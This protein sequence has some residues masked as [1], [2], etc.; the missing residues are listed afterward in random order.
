MIRRTADCRVGGACMDDGADAAV[1]SS[2]RQMRLR[3]A[4]A[5]LAFCLLASGQTKPGVSGVERKSIQRKISGQH[6]AAIYRVA[7][8][9]DWMAITS[10]ATWVA[11]ANVNHV[12]QLDAATDRVAAIVTVSNPCSGLA[13]DFGS[14]W[15]PS[16]GA[17]ALFRVD[18]EAGKIIAKISV[19]PANSEGGITTGAGSVWV[20]TRGGLARI[21]AA[22]NKV[23]ALIRIPSGSYA[24]AFGDGAVWIT[25]TKHSRLTRVD[26]RTNRA[27]ATIVVG[28]RPRFLAVGGGSV[29]TLNQGDG[30]VSR[31]EMKTN[32]LVATIPVGT[33]GPGGEIVFGE[34]AVWTTFFGFP[35]TRIDPLLNRVTEQWTGAGGDSI[36]V[37]DGM[38]WLT[39]YKGGTVSR[40]TLP[41]R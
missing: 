2:L 25:S 31:V 40:F 28:R 12:V 29:W 16:C 13:A 30:T 33:A 24:A 4:I 37:S 21:D 17:H 8:H 5:L 1:K 22:S 41:L 18:L 35:I 36:R 10:T 26:P 32:R 38:L 20:P 6:P 23:V 39:D 19:A 27:V 3:T 15:V 7:G 14:L 34:G 11:A 9:P